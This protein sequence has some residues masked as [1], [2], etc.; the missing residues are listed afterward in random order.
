[1]KQEDEIQ[2]GISDALKIRGH[3]YRGPIAC[4]VATLIH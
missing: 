4:P 3:G 1:M 2:C